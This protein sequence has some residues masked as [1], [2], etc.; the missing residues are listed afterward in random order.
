M[1]KL[2]LKDLINHFYW[3]IRFSKNVIKYKY[4][5]VQIISARLYC[6][7][8]RGDHSRNLTENVESFI[9]IHSL[10]DANLPKFLAEDVPLFESILDDLFPGVVPPEPDYGVLE[11]Q[12]L[13]HFLMS[14][15]ILKLKFESIHLNHIMEFRSKHLTIVMSQRKIIKL[16]FSIL[17]FLGIIL[18]ESDYEVVE[19]QH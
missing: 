18:S 12:Y 16:Y 2:F 19:V 14:Q 15:N 4:Y 6:I 17:E 10:R 13:S 7:N 5:C 11:V 9:L 8:C 3:W 1:Q